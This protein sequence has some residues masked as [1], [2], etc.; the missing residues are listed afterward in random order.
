M[1]YNSVKYYEKKA[2][3]VNETLR[4]IRV[5]NR[6]P[7]KDHTWIKMFKYSHDKSV[8]DSHVDCNSDDN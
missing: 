5:L 6:Q 1:Q 3:K 7:K 8:G 4:N 2:G